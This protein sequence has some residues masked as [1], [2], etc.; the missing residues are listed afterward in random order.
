MSD[1]E[2][3]LRVGMVFVPVFLIGVAA[4]VY[5]VITNR[6]DDERDLPPAE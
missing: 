6:E 5:G 3:L 4:I 2:W 1:L